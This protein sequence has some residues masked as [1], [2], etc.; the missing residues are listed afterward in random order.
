[1]QEPPNDEMLALRSMAET[2][3]WLICGETSPEGSS[4]EPFRV[5]ILF[6]DANPSAVA[7][8]WK[9]SSGVPGFLYTIDPVTARKPVFAR[10]SGVVSVDMLNDLQNPT[11]QIGRA[12]V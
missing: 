4:V 10:R 12:H 5:E 11:P 1:M 3:N 7:E 2:A 6:K 9:N 8:I